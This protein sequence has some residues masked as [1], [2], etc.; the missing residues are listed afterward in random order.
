MMLLSALPLLEL[1]LF[2]GLGSGC[3]FVQRHYR[4]FFECVYLHPYMGFDHISELQT[5]LN[6]PN[7]VVIAQYAPS[8]SVSLVSTYIA[9]HCY[10]LGL[11]NLEAGKASIVATL[12]PVVAAIAAYFFLGEYF[13]I[14]GYIGAV[15]IVAAVILT[16]IR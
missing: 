2:A 6:D 15:M 7:K 8:I 12:E 14:F 10:Y 5:A 3:T 4:T 9:N 16:I 1:L 11:K 13:T